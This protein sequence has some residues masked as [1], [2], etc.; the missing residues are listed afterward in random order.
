MEQ[1]RLETHPEAGGEAAYQGGALWTEEQRRAIDADEPYVFVEAGAGTGKTGVLVDRYCDAVEAAE[2]GTDAVLAF[3]FTEKAAG[4]LRGRVR[5]ELR[6]RAAIAEEAGDHAR[7]RRLRELARSPGAWLTTI[8]GFCRRLLAA[9]PIA[10]GVDP[11]FRVFDQTEADLLAERAFDDAFDALLADPDPAKL[12]LA[13]A[14]V[15]AALRDLVRGAHDELRSL[16]QERPA[17]EPHLPGPTSR[18][19]SSSAPPRARR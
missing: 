6:R 18:A 5:F 10:A 12:T 2:A 7:A 8:H 15:R 3:T 4:E 9:H 17:L 1:L 19:S 13:A 16:G 11:G 14:R